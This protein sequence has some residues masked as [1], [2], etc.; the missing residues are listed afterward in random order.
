[1]EVLPV[2]TVAKSLSAQLAPMKRML[3]QC[4]SVD[5]VITAS[6]KIATI[7]TALRKSGLYKPDAIRPARELW[8]D[9]RGILGHELSKLRKRKDK[10]KVHDELSYRDALK[11]YS[12]NNSEAQRCEMVDCLPPPVKNKVYEYAKV[13]EILPT[14]KMLVDE[15]KPYWAQAN[16]KTKH[17]DIAGKSKKQKM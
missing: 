2:V 14:M 12:I 13:D 17:E 16:R 8:L 15:A 3:A 11:K 6:A 5:D 4:A 9:S 10:P 1:M 7:E